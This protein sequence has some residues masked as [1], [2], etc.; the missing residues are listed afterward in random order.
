M[1]G[2]I[3]PEQD[4]QKVKLV[5]QLSSFRTATT[6][7]GDPFG[8]AVLEDISG[9]IEVVAWKEVYQRTQA[10]WV[11]GSILKVEGRV[12]LRNGDRVSVHCNSVQKFDLPTE[13]D[14]SETPPVI[15]APSR[16]KMRR[17]VN[18]F[19]PASNHLLNQQQMEPFSL[20]LPIGA[21][22]IPLALPQVRRGGSK[23]QPSG[24]GKP[25]PLILNLHQFQPI[26]NR[27]MVPLTP[28]PPSFLRKRDSIPILLP[29]PRRSLAQNTRH[30]RRHPGR[31]D[32]QRRPNHSQ[33]VS[34]PQCPIPPNRRT[35]PNHSLGG[36]RRPGG[37]FPPP[38]QAPLTPPRRWRNH[39][40]RS[41]DPERSPENE[42]GP[43]SHRPRPTHR[44]N[45]GRPPLLQRHSISPQPWRHQRLSRRLHPTLWHPRSG[46]HARRGPHRH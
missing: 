24:M 20:S 22:R 1:C 29:Q 3:S 19:P 14:E 42:V 40:G 35:L 28:P 43:S 38:R 23:D 25:R 34:R 12:R 15:P 39:P 44:R 27:K 17:G 6:R 41:L 32:A 36:P 9:S 18:P 45:V 4:G 26:G 8:A 13:D 31:R 37:V 2:D 11:D 30:G 7:R 5:G 33:A 21:V 16:L 10:L 46:A